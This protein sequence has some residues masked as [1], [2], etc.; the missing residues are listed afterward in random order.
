MNI[1]D[2]FHPMKNVIAVPEFE[3][4][5][6]VDIFLLHNDFLFLGSAFGPKKSTRRP[7]ILQRVISALSSLPAGIVP[8]GKR[9]PLS[10]WSSSLSEVTAWREKDAFRFCLTDWPLFV[11]YFVRCFLLCFIL[12]QVLLI[13]FVTTQWTIL[14]LILQI[15]HG[16]RNFLPCHDNLLLIISKTLSKKRDSH[17]LDCSH[18]PLL[19]TEHSSH[20]L[21]LTGL[22]QTSLRFIFRRLGLVQRPPGKLSKHVTAFY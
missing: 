1:L 17:V 2:E 12:P 4:L 16:L 19:T 6:A 21:R 7:P 8:K 3:R 22:F 10:T 15:S 14:S 20:F 13:Y 9:T 11:I 5:N 18:R